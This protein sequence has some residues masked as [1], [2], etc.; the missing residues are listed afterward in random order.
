M[1]YR[2]NLV[3]LH[4]VQEWATERLTADELNK[5]LLFA[6]DCHRQTVWYLAASRNRHDLL[7]IL[8]EWAKEKL[9]TEEII[10]ELFLATDSEA[11]VTHRQII[12]N[13]L[14]NLA[15]EGKIKH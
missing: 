4:R 2:D 15:K 14:Q 5:M 1:S 8:W 12:V 9:T 6:G 11:T 7:Q 3:V 10:N 13:E